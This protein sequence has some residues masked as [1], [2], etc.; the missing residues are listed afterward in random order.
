[1]TAGRGDALRVAYLAYRGNP[2]S[3][4]QGVYTRYLTAELASMGHTVEV[5]GGQPYPVLEDG[6]GFTPVPSLDLYR[7][8]DPFRVP[9]LREFKD[10]IDVLEFAYMCSAAFPEPLTYSLR[11]RKLLSGRRGDFDV[12]HDN[13]CF[14]TGLLGLIAEGWPLV[15][16]L[17]HPITVD[18]DLELSHAPSAFRRMTL[19]RW[20]SFLHMQMKV[21]RQVESIVTVSESSKRDVVDQ[22]GVDADR[23]TVVPVGVDHL[24]F[25]P[26][27]D[28]AKVPGRL[29]TT[30]SADV[31]LKGLVPL[32]EALAKVRTE[33]HV[34]LVIVGKPRPQTR[35]GETVARLGL[36]DSVRFVSGVSDDEIVR[37]YNQAEV[38]VVP[39]L[40]E[41]FSL[42]AIEAMACGTPLVATTGGA[43]PEVVG[44]SGET[45]LLVPA[46]DPEALAA[47][48]GAALDN[49]EFRA[50]LG[51]AG[52][53]RVLER[54]TWR[55]CA[56]GTV[57]AY[58]DLLDRKAGP[59]GLG[60]PPAAAIPVGMGSPPEAAGV[61]R[62][63]RVPVA[64]DIA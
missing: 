13:Q 9:H 12:I 39:S 52:R 57:E 49:S 63:T 29:M 20:Y 21:A 18:R 23:M 3:G 41:G 62:S 34:E 35:V 40:Y 24:R 30:A 22:M 50:R 59:A 55:A 27:P 25:R 7:Q 15:A 53:R 2:H 44:T 8:P 6:V 60:S 5:F 28:V 48:L 31:P 4:G 54:F 58:H 51:E 16:T 19:R 45:G 32:L 61:V 47:A 42:P 1:M 17:H 36:G 11:L 14:G 46:G 38:A 10:R 33:R 43:L 26:L 64:G 56:E 37:L